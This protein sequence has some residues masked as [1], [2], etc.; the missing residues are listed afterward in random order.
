M[1]FENSQNNSTFSPVFNDQLD[2]ELKVNSPIEEE[3]SPI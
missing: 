2:D 1:N 3:Y